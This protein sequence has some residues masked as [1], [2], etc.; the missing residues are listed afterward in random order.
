MLETRHDLVR[1][2]AEVLVQ[3]RLHGTEL[4][5]ARVGAV[6]ERGNLIGVGRPPRLLACNPGLVPLLGGGDEIGGDEDVLPEERRQLLT[7]GGAVVR[8]DRGAN[9]GLVFE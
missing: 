5:E 8:L 1:R 4:P 6:E 7:G 9:V 2:K 3:H